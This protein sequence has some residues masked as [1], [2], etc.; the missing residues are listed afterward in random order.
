LQ[1]VE[2][3]G[4]HHV[5]VFKGCGKPLMRKSMI[6][7]GIAVHGDSGLGKGVEFPDPVKLHEEGNAILN[8]YQTIK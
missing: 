4:L 1:I 8:I 7:K 6:E 3:A 5:K 2:A